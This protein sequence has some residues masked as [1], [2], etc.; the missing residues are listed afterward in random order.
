M[1]FIYNLI[2]IILMGMLFRKKLNNNKKKGL[3]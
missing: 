1:V 3:F 2:F